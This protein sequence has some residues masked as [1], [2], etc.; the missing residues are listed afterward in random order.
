MDDSNGKI[1]KLFK[2][3]L[4]ASADPT[5]GTGNVVN[6]NAASQGNVF[7]VGNNNNNV[8]ITS[9]S[10]VLNPKIR[11]GEHHLSS[12]QAH[13]IRQLVNDIVQ[14]E[15]HSKK[16]PRNH[17]AVWTSL[18][19]KFKFSKY[20]LVE[21][22][23]YDEIVSYLRQTL[24]RLKR[25]KQARKAP[26]WRTSRYRYIYTKIKE[27][28]LLE[29]KDEY[30]ESNFGVGSMKDLSDSELQAFYDVVASKSKA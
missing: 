1:R 28:A 4:D 11:P 9:Q 25:S 29:W 27:Q 20:E 30:L 15:K 3:V 23:K 2:D 19:R 24:G 16:T 14:A 6:I 17:A 18:K 26:D 8:N 12:E 7:S 13:T 21:Q 5:P 10:V 22:H